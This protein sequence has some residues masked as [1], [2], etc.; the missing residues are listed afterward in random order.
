M[1]NK[2]TMFK[3]ILI[4]STSILLISANTA[5][6]NVQIKSTK[7]TNNIHMLTGQGGNLGAFIGKDG[8]FLID[9]QF[10]PL[11]DK[12]VAKLKQLGG[13]T[14]KFLINT[15]FHGDHSGGNE[16]FGK[17][18]ALIVSHHNVRKRLKWGYEIKAFNN[19][20]GP[21]PE[22]ALPVMTFDSQMHF[23]LN[24]DNV[25]AIHV[26][27][28]HTDG[29]SF[30]HFK[31]ANVIHAGD[32]FFNG[33]Y[34]FLD[35]NNGGSFKGLIAA[36]KKMLALSNGNTKIIPGH[37][38]LA[39]KKDL[40]TYLAMLEGVNKNFSQFKAQGLSNAQV[41]AK[42]PLKS[43]EQRWGNGIFTSDKWIDVIYPN[44]F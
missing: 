36:I 1:I 12:I 16:N 27:K 33:F 19:K 10:A 25:Q 20:T 23:H 29:D 8:T 7:V 18:G 43:L 2:V 22:K 3:K 9:D 38:P 44:A 32:L 30:I 13:D 39:N 37:G 26:P 6:A 24:G 41:K 17:K 40:Q 15:H 4:A 14:P 11:S 35:A 21:A 42:K 31:K 28:A 34:P 5:F